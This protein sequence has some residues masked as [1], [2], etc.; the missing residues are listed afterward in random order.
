MT[1]TLNLACRPTQRR[2]ARFL[3]LGLILL[4]FARLTWQL[5]AK[6]LWLD[7][8]FSLQ[9]AE[10]PWPE[11][12]AGCL[13][14][15]DGVMWVKTTDQHPFAYFIFLGL[16]VRTL[17]Q[18]EFALRFPSVIAATLIVPAIW[19]FGRRLARSKSAPP[20]TPLWA[21]LLAALSPFYLWFGQEV[22]MYAQVGLLALLSTYLLLR[23]ADAEKPTGRGR[24]LA[25]YG[26]TLF[27][28]IASHY[29]APLI[30]PVHAA[31]ALLTLRQRHRGRAALATAGL[32]A[33]GLI[34]GTLALWL[35]ARDLNAGTNWAHVSPRILIPDLVN[36]FTLGLSVDLAQVWPLDVLSAALALF[37]ALYGLVRRRGATAPHGWLLPGLLVVPPALLLLINAIRP[38]YMT[39]RHMSLISA[40]FILLAA[41]G[42]AR[43]WYIRRWM[44]AIAAV[45]LVAGALFSTVSYFTQP[46]YDK[47]EHAAMGRYLA[48]RVQPGDLVLFRPIPWGR[49]YRYYFPVDAIERGEQAGLGTSWRILPTGFPAEAPPRPTA[50]TPA[51]TMLDQLVLRLYGARAWYECPTPPPPVPNRPA[52]PTRPLFTPTRDALIGELDALIPHFRRVWLVRSD[53]DDPVSEW[54]RTRG[55][56]ADSR[57]FASPAAMLR[58][59][60]ILTE[61][62]VRKEPPTTITHRTDVRFADQVRLIGY[63]IGRPLM[64]GGSLP[65]TLYWQPLAP[66]ARRY[67][68]ILAVM[69]AETL[70]ATSLRQPPTEIEPYNGFLATPIWP[71]NATIVE[72]TGVRVPTDR[73][74][75]AVRLTLQ[76][77]DAETLEKLP[78][79]GTDGVE[80]G[81]DPFTVILY[82]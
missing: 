19:A 15:T 60:L 6:D 23:W 34:P 13:P 71:A 5:D 42:L 55:F 4:A 20:P 7:E 48:E 73:S 32:I 82:P 72:Y 53:G 27:L 56:H 41:A 26:L 59:D 11:L 22:R 47:G 76:V 24:W 28:L 18:S 31:V 66:L 39:A 51:K 78:I 49:L 37:G 45:P 14:L 75:D 80:V 36:A 46:A 79:A 77:Y 81:A 52:G 50:P 10:E 43:L 25:G 8:S 62:P 1:G 2:S 58:I 69:P 68:Y 57:Q 44:G 61:S 64:A 30:L 35:L 16:A 74:P 54:L 65:V 67:K 29:F 21:A 63:D 70:P 17:G 40:F 12:I 33:L 3:L 9:R 38:A